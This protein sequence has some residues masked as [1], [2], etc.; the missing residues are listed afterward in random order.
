M[1]TPGTAAWLRA[2]AKEHEGLAEGLIRAANRIERLQNELG[3]QKTGVDQANMPAPAPY[4]KA[5]SFPRN[6]GVVKPRL[7]IFRVRLPEGELASAREAHD[8]IF[9][10]INGSEHL[11]M[12]LLNPAILCILGEP[13]VKGG[14]WD[15]DPTRMVATAIEGE[16]K[17]V[18]GFVRLCGTDCKGPFGIL[19]KHTGC[20]DLTGCTILDVESGDE[21]IIELVA[22]TVEVM[23]IEDD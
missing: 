23:E 1:S 10:W 12:G 16:G 18:K 21:T 6:M 22:Q 4:R 2:M 7:P 13:D 9:D 8:R 20:I 5:P 15:L 14:T 3:M 11:G 19:Q 17:G